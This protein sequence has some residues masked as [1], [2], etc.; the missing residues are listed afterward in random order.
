MSVTLRPMR[1]DEFRS[2]YDGQYEN[3][4]RQLIEFAGLSP[5]AARRKATAD[6]GSLLG[7]GGLA[8]EGHSVFV[9]DADGARVGTLWISE[10]ERDHGRFLWIFD[11]SVDPEQRGRGYGREAMLLAEEEARR[12]GLPAV[13]LNVFGGND[14]ARGLYRSL[15]YRENSVW[16]SKDV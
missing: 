12:R 6:H 5:E 3:Y 15:G 8:T 9:L 13:Q 2:W 11:V 16:M 7:E 1:D 10:Q 4:E 14:V